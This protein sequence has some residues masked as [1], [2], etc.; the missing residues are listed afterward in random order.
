MCFAE[1]T[2]YLVK[3]IFNNHRQFFQIH[4]ILTF[5]WQVLC[6]IAA[7][8]IF[9]KL[10]GRSASVHKKN[11]TVDIL[12]G[13]INEHFCWKKCYDIKKVWGYSKRASLR[14]RGGK[15]DK[16]RNKKWRRG[17]VRSQKM[18]CHSLKKKRDFVSDVLFEWLLWWCFILLYFLWVY[19]LMVS[20]DFYETNKPYISK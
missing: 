8:N 12:L 7:L 4:L 10:T 17:R 13:I 20:L 5:H 18:W 3:N 9:G 1:S 2:Q 16:K 15:V 11:S 19:L 14:K 6:R